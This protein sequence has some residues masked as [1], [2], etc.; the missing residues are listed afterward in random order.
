MALLMFCLIVCLS[1]YI[2]FIV[3]FL[4]YILKIPNTFFQALL[5]LLFMVYTSIFDK[6]NTWPGDYKINIENKT[7]KLYKSILKQKVLC[8]K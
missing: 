5:D 8:R 3:S 4:Y 2:Q 1:P 6:D 7:K